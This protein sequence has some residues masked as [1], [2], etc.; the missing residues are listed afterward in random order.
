VGEVGSV[1]PVTPN[2]EIN[3]LTSLF[4]MAAAIERLAAEARM[5]LG[6]DSMFNALVS[7]ARVDF[8]QAKIDWAGESGL[9]RRRSQP[10]RCGSQ[11]PLMHGRRIRT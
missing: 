4:A 7:S 6:G 2:R 5:A 10:G 8:D 1:L 9:D 3:L 11:S